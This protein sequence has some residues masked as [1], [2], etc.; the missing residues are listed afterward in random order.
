M[1]GGMTKDQ[2]LKRYGSQLKIAEA[3]GISQPSVSAWTD[4]IPELRQLQLERLTAGEL[5]AGPECD[6]FKPAAA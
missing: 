5:R 2:V 3:L 1:L 6:Q 4:P